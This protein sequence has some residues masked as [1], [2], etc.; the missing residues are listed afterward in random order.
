MSLD[1]A[2]SGAMAVVAM[3]KTELLNKLLADLSEKKKLSKK[4][5]EKVDEYVLNMP[6]KLFIAES[7][8][9]NQKINY[10]LKMKDT[11]INPDKVLK[12]IDL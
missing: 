3:R 6:S 1:Y 10:D 12:E 5:E 7:E 11:E 2:F 4:E 8:K 9:K